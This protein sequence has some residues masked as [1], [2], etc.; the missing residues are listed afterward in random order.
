MRIGDLDDSVTRIDD[1]DD[2]VTM[3]DDLDESLVI[4]PS[5]ADR[6]LA[7]GNLGNEICKTK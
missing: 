7:N 5:Q 6:P 1:L 3:I 2:N 4:T